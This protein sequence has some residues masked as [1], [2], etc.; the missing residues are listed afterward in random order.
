MAAVSIIDVEVRD[1]AFKRFKDQ[2]D[3]F[4]TA[5][6]NQ[7]AAWAAVS[8]QARNVEVAIASTNTAMSRLGAGQLNLSR[9]S[10]GI[11]KTFQGI[12]DSSTKLAK[13]VAGIT[14][15]LVRWVG[16]GSIFT[17]LLGGGGLFGLDRMAKG[18]ASTRQ[19]ALAS[20]I[21]Y[22]EAKAF[23]INYNRYGLDLSTVH[24]VAEARSNL[25]DIPAFGALGVSPED[26]K[27][28]DPAQLT[29]Q[30]MKRARDKFNQGGGNQQYAEANQLTKFFSMDQLR[31]FSKASDEDL[32]KSA[33]TFKKDAKEFDQG[34][35]TQSAWVNLV[36]SLQRAGEKIDAVLVKGLAD[37]AG[38]IGDLSEKFADAVKIFLSN[39]HLKEWIDQFGTGIE[40]VARYIGTDKF[41]DN[42]T[43][44]VDGV[45][46]MA[47]AIGR[48]IA[49]ID[50]LFTG[51]GDKTPGAKGGDVQNDGQPASKFTSWFP[52]L[53]PAK[54]PQVPTEGKAFLD[55]VASGESDGTYADQRNKTSGA[56]GKYQFLDSTWKEISG[57]TGLSDFTPENQDRNA[58]SYAQE[59]YKISTHGRDL[60]ADV[61]TNQFQPSGLNKIWTS[62][63]GGAEPNNQT[64]G[65]EDR[66]R[67]TENNYQQAE[68][69]KKPVS[70][71][72]AI[73]AATPTFHND[74]DGY[75]TAIRR[76][77][78]A[79]PGKAVSFDSGAKNAVMPSVPID[80]AIKAAVPTFHDDDDRA[81]RQQLRAN[82]GKA[83]SFDSSVKRAVGPNPDDA[84]KTPGKV[85][86]VE[87]RTPA[88][89]A[90]NGG[91]RVTVYNNTG[92]NAIVSAGMA[93]V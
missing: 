22:G 60:G 4:Q 2:F 33:S 13:N 90:S 47:A 91:A 9:Q 31:T 57:K 82:P 30:M 69:A 78:L 20:G 3:I 56:R 15:D 61:K 64:P 70:V 71:D 93:A 84:P 87:P 29:V 53:V 17:G 68:T 77:L 89:F 62:I 37:L 1:E 50:K 44:F 86:E 10:I 16:F 28:L 75:G 8:G 19:T 58:W 24:R 54:A 59:R 74:N 40:N 34:D 63:P 12:A 7:P 85:S 73:K 43:N 39:P 79:N 55:T 45:A 48:A 26:R 18:V 83:I 11:A 52:G 21:G 72:D 5:V 76:Q 65:W 32:D 35:P 14:R 42:V 6:K 41:K 67:Q 49:W 81:L 23:D 51:N 66:L 25:Q 38:P 88:R 46:N 27:N 36:S 92:G 80:D